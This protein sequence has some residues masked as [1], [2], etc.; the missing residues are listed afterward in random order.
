MTTTKETIEVLNDLSSKGYEAVKSL[1]D[2][3][4]R[5]MERALARQMDALSICM[6]G[7]LRSFKLVTESKGPTDLVRGQADLLRE[8]SEKMLIESREAI[9]FAT[10]SRDEYRTW[11]EQ[12][13]QVVNDRMAKLRSTA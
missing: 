10:D 9:K 6:D 2:I 12:G 8:F 4:L 7:G 5:I 13:L 1:G 3:N 11:F